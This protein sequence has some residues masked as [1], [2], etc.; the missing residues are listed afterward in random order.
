M[1]K[2][3]VFTTPKKELTPEQ[4]QELLSK[5]KTRFDKNISCHQGLEWMKVQTKLE[6]NAGKLWS[7]SEMEKTGGEPDVIGYDEKAG[8]YVFVDFSAESP[9]GRRNVCY[10]YE[11][12]QEREKHGI[13]PAGNAVDMAAFIGIGLFTRRTVSGAAKARRIRCENTELGQNAGGY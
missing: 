10:D 13:H 1:Q 8:E 4:R 12:Q 9:K 11:G 3:P 7:L 5:L 2:S 6:A